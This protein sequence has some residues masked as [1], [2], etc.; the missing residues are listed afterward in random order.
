VILRAR[1]IL[2]ITAPPIENGA[3]VVS[4]NSIRAVDSWSVLKSRFP[5]D[6]IIDLGEVIFL[7]GLINA[8]CHLDYTDM[9]GMLPPPRKFT[10]WIPL[11][12]AAKAEWS[13]TDYARS[14]LN[15]AQ[16]LLQTG[17]TTVADIE[18]VPELLPEMW[19]AT[20]LRVFSFLEM[21]GVKSKRDP[22]A[23]LHL[24]LEKAR[25]LS[26]PRSRVALSPHAPYST[27]PELLRLCATAAR[28]NTLLLATHV[29]ESEQEFE[30]FT[31]AGGEMFKWLKRNGRTMDDCGLGSPVLHVKR[32]G[33]LGENFL[34]IHV[35]FLTSGDAELLAKNKASVVH[36]PRSHDYFRH[37]PFQQE[38]LAATGLNLCLGTDS[39]ATVRKKP[40]EKVALNMFT[41]MQK[42]A[43][44]AK[45]ITPDEI[46]RMATVNGARAIGMA[47]RIGEL[48]ENAFADLIAI[49]FSGNI[50][51]AVAAVVQHSGKVSASM[52]GGEW[53][54]R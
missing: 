25:S 17:T 31:R 33:L 39:L 10:D 19:D 47:G 29:A 46:L 30:M 1:T 45:T 28:E 12:L 37:P 24:A 43:A 3:V 22:A 42:L 44:N 36:C 18:A 9:A 21:T 35:N 11:M 41:E 23:I 53:A 2:P 54:I 49:P 48:S 27:S 38:Q 15:G 32:S 6:E 4:G 51:D 40:R 7:P 8:H 5:D 26:H 13:Y 14:W 52:I 16:M 34:A 20:P 50:S